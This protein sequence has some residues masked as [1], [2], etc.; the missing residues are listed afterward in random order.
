[1]FHSPSPVRRRWIQGRIGWWAW[2]GLRIS[3]VALVL[4]LLAH[5]AVISTSLRGPDA[6][7]RLL[8]LLQSPP[9]VVADLFLLLAVLYHGV[10]GLRVMLLEAG[11][12][13]RHQERLFWAGLGITALAMAGA[14][15][16]VWPLI[17]RK[18][19]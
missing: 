18:G 15:W 9:F 6:F 11:V 5:I 1:M 8:K 4:Y 14:T 19:V 10:M 17:F 7:D 3:G 16:A 12:S 2:L 13:L